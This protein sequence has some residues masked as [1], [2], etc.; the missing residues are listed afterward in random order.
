LEKLQP[1]KILDYPTQSST[2]SRFLIELG[3]R[4]QPLQ[5][6][7]AGC[8]RRWPLH[9]DGTQYR[10]TGVDLDPHGMEARKKIEGDLNEAIIGDLRD[11]ELPA[12]KYDVIYSAYVLEHVEGAEKVLDNFLSWLSK[13]G[14]IVLMIPDR[15]TVQG[16]V[17]RITPYWFH[18][19]F[20]RYVQRNPNAGKPGFG[21]FPTCHDK[22]VSRRGIHEYCRRN[23]LR[24]KH[25]HAH[26]FQPKRLAPLIKGATRL[27]SMLSFGS[28]EW[29]YCDVI[30]V[31][32]RK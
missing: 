27:I 8:G 25:E 20:K 28:L 13:D 16:F 19:A 9:L 6:L 26:I 2:L 18:V 29:R 14:L 30:L 23:S 3:K 22:I 31:L 12:G 1:L 4:H 11:I 17:A 10:L 32:E 15:D 7:E 21:P 24:V 5:I